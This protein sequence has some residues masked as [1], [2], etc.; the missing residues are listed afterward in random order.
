MIREGGMDPEEGRG[1]GVFGGM[2]G[3][4]GDSE[5][6]WA[7]RDDGKRKSLRIGVHHANAVVWGPV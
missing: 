3:D 5:G 1:E 6:P 4:D 7:E 2:G